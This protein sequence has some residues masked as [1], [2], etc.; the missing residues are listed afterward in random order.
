MS[1]GGLSTP[2]TTIQRYRCHH[3]TIDAPITTLPMRSSVG[4]EPDLHRRRPLS[5]LN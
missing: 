5:L 3:P 4:I 1:P 2:T